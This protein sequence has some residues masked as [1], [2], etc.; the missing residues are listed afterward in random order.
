MPFTTWKD[1]L[2]HIAV[3][4][5][6]KERRDYGQ[7]ERTEKESNGPYA[8]YKEKQKEVGKEIMGLEEENCTIAG[9]NCTLAGENCTLAGRP[10]Y[11]KF[12]STGL[13][14]WVTIAQVQSRYLFRHDHKT[15][16]I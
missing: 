16:Y 4:I 7:T 14:S 10:A 3:L 5:L 11:G 8:K 6:S 9:E 1:L 15:V 13:E 2:I 12:Y